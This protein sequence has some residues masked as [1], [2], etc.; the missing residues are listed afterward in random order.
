HRAFEMLRAAVAATLDTR[1]LY[2]Q[3]ALS[4]ANHC[5]DV[6]RAATLWDEYLE[7]EHDAL[8]GDLNRAARCAEIRNRPAVGLTDRMHYDAA[9]NVLMKLIEQQEDIADT[10]ARITGV[11]PRSSYELGA[12]YGSLGQIEAFTG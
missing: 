11:A 10:F 12:C 8:A 4:H 3:I 2:L 6:E 5:G 7:I 9:R 1:L